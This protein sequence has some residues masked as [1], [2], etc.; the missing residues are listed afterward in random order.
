M[1]LRSQS[2]I[3]VS[4]WLALLLGSLGTH[5]PAL[6]F[7]CNVE[8]AWAL[9]PRWALLQNWKESLEGGARML[10]GREKE[11]GGTVRS[12]STRPCGPAAP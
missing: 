9:Y 5:T 2:W 10:E 4:G 1:Q 7:P 3:L 11:P 6:F 12:K 8:L